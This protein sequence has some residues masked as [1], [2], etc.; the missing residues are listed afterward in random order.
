[1]VVTGVTLMAEYTTPLLDSGREGNLF[2]EQRA[3]WLTTQCVRRPALATGTCSI[4][5]GA[6]AWADNTIHTME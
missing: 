2:S 1:M 6:G 5:A 3:Q 4:G